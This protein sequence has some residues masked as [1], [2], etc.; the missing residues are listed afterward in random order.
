MGAAESF[1]P[2]FLGAYGDPAGRRRSKR[3]WQRS[4]AAGRL[5]RDL[6]PI[7]AADGYRPAQLIARLIHIASGLLDHAAAASGVTSEGALQTVAALIAAQG[8]PDW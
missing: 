8:D 4:R 2:E 1:V 7:L 5:L 3:L 6:E